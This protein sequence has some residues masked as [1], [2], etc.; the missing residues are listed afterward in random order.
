M[1]LFK[2]LFEKLFKHLRFVL[3]GTECLPMWP[4]TRLPSFVVPG[5]PMSEHHAGGMS[6]STVI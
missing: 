1:H 6:V 3:T 2:N 5:G 4:D